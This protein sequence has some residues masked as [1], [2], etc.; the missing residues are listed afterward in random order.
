MAHLENGLGDEEGEQREAA[1][2]IRVPLMA[3][4]GQHESAAILWTQ[5]FSM[6]SEGFTTET[7]SNEVMPAKE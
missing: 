6:S 2:S 5:V 4:V 3:K 7:K 1:I